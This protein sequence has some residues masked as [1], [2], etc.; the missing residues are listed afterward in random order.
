MI[1]LTGKCALVTGAGTRVG[2]EIAS[3]LGGL[4]MRVAVH[5][6]SSLDGAQS[7]CRAIEQAGGQG[8][9]IQ[10]DL[11]EPGQSERLVDETLAALGQLD[12][13]VP[14]AANYERVAMATIER[15][16]FARALDLNLVAPFQLVQRAAPALRAT[17]GSVVL[18]TDA[19][20]LA[21]YR[22]FLPYEVSK[23]ALHQMMR[24]LALELAPD[25]RV[26]AVAPGTV[27]PPTNMSSAELAALAARIPLGRFG[28]A[29]SVAEAVVYLARAGFVTGT[30]LMV[31]GGRAL[32]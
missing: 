10:A 27:L 4:R 8:V 19:G 29:S 32:A 16:H 26:N 12:L 28:G 14:S 17:R 1:D 13:L 2:A 22:D 23:A 3:A 15:A 25:V 9:P 6:H 11:S 18:I 31:D 20:R 7:I 30:E 21:P 5:Y 24:V